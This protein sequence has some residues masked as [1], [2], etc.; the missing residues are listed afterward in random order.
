MSKPTLSRKLYLMNP[1][2]SPMAK[3]AKNP[4]LSKR[5]TSS[6]TNSLPKSSSPAQAKTLSFTKKPVTAHWSPNRKIL[7]PAKAFQAAF[8]N[9]PATLQNSFIG[10][11]TQD[12]EPKLNF[13]IFAM[14]ESKLT[15]EFKKSTQFQKNYITKP[16]VTSNTSLRGPN[17]NPQDPKVTVQDYDIFSRVENRGSGLGKNCGQNPKIP[18]NR[19]Q[20]LSSPKN[21]DISLLVKSRDFLNRTTHRDYHQKNKYTPRNSL[22]MVNGSRTERYGDGNIMDSSLWTPN[23][24]KTLTHRSGL[25]SRLSCI[26]RFWPQGKNGPQEGAEGGQGGGSVYS[27]YSKK[28]LDRFMVNREM[29]VTEC[30]LSIGRL[31]GELGGLEKRNGLLEDYCRE[32]DR[33][34]QILESKISDLSSQCCAQDSLVKKNKLLE[35][36]NFGLR[37]QKLESGEGEG[38]LGLAHR[39]SKKVMGE[40]LGEWKILQ[41]GFSEQIVR[42]R[43]DQEIFDCENTRKKLDYLEEKF[44][45]IFYENKHYQKNFFKK[46]FD[47]VK[48]EAKLQEAVRH[49]QSLRAQLTQKKESKFELEKMRLEFDEKQEKIDRFIKKN[50]EF[51]T[52][53]SK[54]P[55]IGHHRQNN[56]SLTERNSVNS[57]RQEKEFTLTN[58]VILLESENKR[59][60]SLIKAKESQLSKLT[61]CE[62][63][64]G[65]EM[66]SVLE[67][68]EHLDLQYKT[69]QL[70]YQN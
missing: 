6:P 42:A 28:T 12:Y 5:T 7:S 62:R 35:Q 9:N 37:A 10:S 21:A 60:L 33:Q 22:S 31:V 11:T 48:V 66:N 54:G 34:K 20:N 39:D 43:R 23:P 45:L 29:G 46:S 70:N 49:F 47:E 50:L 14:P 17:P 44:K 65:E 61:K 27:K 59:L 41:R 36:E 13:P 68:N 32:K 19:D 69:M 18:K 63:D 25:G 53:T 4:F 55:G 56:F 38:D 15:E 67:K 64:V 2:Y 30:S 16:G 8:N 40:M 3:Y 1:S 26:D 57:S 51:L 52:T 58:E 24:T